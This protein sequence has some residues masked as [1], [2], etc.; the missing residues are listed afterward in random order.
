MMN[1][2][3]SI[4]SIPVAPG[5]LPL[6]GSALPLLRDPMAFLRTM[7]ARGK[8]V[9]LRIGPARAVLVCDPGLTGEV[10]RNDRTFDKGGPLWDRGREAVGNGIV[11]CPH[12]DHRRQ[13]RIVQPAFHPTRMA[14]YA[15]TMST[16][17][18]IAADSWNEGQILDVITEMKNV[19]ATIAVE[20][21]FSA[22]IESEAKLKVRDDLDTI[23]AG[24]YRRMVLPPVLRNLP[25]AENRRYA[26]AGIRLRTTLDRIV[27]DR[28]AERIDHGDLLSGLMAEANGISDSEVGDQVVAFY[29]AGSETAANTLAWV[30]HLLDRHPDVEQRIHAEVDSVLT[31]RI[32]RF[33]DISQLAYTGRVVT[34]TLRLY[35]P[36]WL[37]SRIAT[38]DAELGGYLIPAGTGILLSSYLI[39]HRADIFEDPE[40]FDPD[41]WDVNPDQR[42]ARDGFIPF[43]AG[44]RRCIGDRFAMATTTLTLATIVARWRLLSV[45]KRPVRPAL[46]AALRPRNFRLRATARQPV[47]RQVSE[48]GVPSRC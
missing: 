20:T 3:N 21:M 34:E 29:A 39:H 31:D 4:R 16:H 35:P 42:P 38:A 24:L 5:T 2:R 48:A 47:G 10:L 45:A 9:Q 30:F 6:F 43:G 33:E 14:G 7:P 25:T 8:L 41:R 18:A 22:H 13:R 23:A 46:S 44:P 15:R 19:T 11:T 37:F 26:G 36:G 17:A 27:A 40:R 12:S 28:R 1:S 32:A